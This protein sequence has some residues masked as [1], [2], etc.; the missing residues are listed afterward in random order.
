M[1]ILGIEAS[2]R[3]SGR[4]K[5]VMDMIQS[6]NG[7][8]EITDSVY[9]F[10]SEGNLANSEGMLMAALGGAMAAGAKVDMVYLSEDFK[11]IKGSAA[12][13]PDTLVKT[14]K[15]SSGL[16]FSTPVYF[17][18]RSSFVESLFTFVTESFQDPYPLQDKTVGLLSVGAKRNGGQETTN[19]FSLYDSQSLG[20]CVVG[21]GPPT[22]QYGGTGWAGDISRILDDDWGLKTAFG[23]GRRVAQISSIRNL[24]MASLPKL[25]L[26]FGLPQ[27]QAKD[28][29]IG[30]FKELIEAAG[31]EAEVVKVYKR[32]IKRCRACPICPNPKA[33]GDYYRCI[34]RDAMYDLMDQLRDLDGLI[35]TAELGH[36]FDGMKSYQ[37]FMERTRCVRRNHFQWSNLPVG[38]AVSEAPHTNSIFTLRALSSYLRHNVFLVGPF[39]QSLVFGGQRAENIPLAGYVDR[40]VAAAR[41][42]K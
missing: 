6:S 3:A 1:E 21:N 13:S 15:N 17:G 28:N 14:L 2:I 4:K 40:L 35:V 16:I 8:A 37:L 25:K 41:Q 33:K 9:E 39:Y 12:S 19:I 24:D 29:L 27:F 32:K 26:K 36:A 20:A 11:K 31:H 38:L 23:V 30:R 5:K 22:S 7:L 10:A 42:A 34:V 18:D